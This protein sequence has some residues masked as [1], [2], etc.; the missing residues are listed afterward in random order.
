MAWFLWSHVEKKTI[1]AQLLGGLEQVDFCIHIKG[2][3]MQT[4]CNSAQ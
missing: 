1:Y 2:K 4:G 3:A